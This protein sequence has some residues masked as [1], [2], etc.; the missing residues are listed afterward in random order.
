MSAGILVLLAPMTGLVRALGDK[1]PLPLD[2]F[3]MVAGVLLCISALATVVLHRQRL[4]ALLI[5][6]VGGIDCVDGISFSAPDLALTQLTVEVVTIVLLLLALF[7]PQRTPKETGT[8]Q[9]RR[10]LGIANHRRRH[11]WYAELRV[12]DAVTGQ[13][14]R[15]FH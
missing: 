6:S 7:W 8:P 12:D 3:A 9:D 4:I 13:Y 10:D 5:L 1:A 2:P 11:L 14:L 15:L